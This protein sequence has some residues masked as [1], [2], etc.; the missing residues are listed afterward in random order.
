MAPPRTYSESNPTVV[1]FAKANVSYVDSN[2]KKQTRTDYRPAPGSGYEILTDDVLISG[3]LELLNKFQKDH[4]AELRQEKNANAKRYIDARIRSA[5]KFRAL[6]NKAMLDAAQKKFPPKQEVVDKDG[7][8][9]LADMKYPDYQTS[10]NGCWS[11]SYSLLLKSRG[12]ELSQEEIRQWRPDYKENAAPDTKPNSERKRLMNVDTGNSIYPNAD[13]VGK[14]LPNTAVN[15]LHLDPFEPG[16]LSID[17]KPLSAAQQQTVQEEYHAQVKEKLQTTI[18]ESFAQHQSPVS[19]S[20]DGHFITITGISADG[21]TIRYEESLGAENNSPR[22]RTMTMDELVK[23]G[24]SAH[25]HNGVQYDR[26]YG[27]E[28]TWL[29]DLPVAEHGKEQPGLHPENKDYVTVGDNGSVTVSVPGNDEAFSIAGSPVQGQV[30]SRAVEKQMVLDQ[31][32]LARRLG[33]KKIDG[34]G[35]GGGILCGGAGTFYPG[36][37]MRPGDPSLAQKA[38]ASQKKNISKVESGLNYMQ[39]QVYTEESAQK[40]QECLAALKDLKAIAKGDA[41]DL[42]KDKEKLSGLCDYLAQKPEGSDKTHF[43]EIFYYM[44]D[45]SRKAF[46]ENLSHFNVLLGLGKEKECGMFE[47]LHPKMEQ[48][49]SRQVQKSTN[50]IKLNRDFR[51]KIAGYWDTVKKNAAGSEPDSPEQKQMHDAL[52]K[53]AATYTLY[54]QMRDAG[55]DPPYPSEEEISAL[56]PKIQSFDAFQNTVNGSKDWM[57]TSVPEDFVKAFAAEENRLREATKD[58]NRYAIPEAYLS[59]RQNRFKSIAKRLDK[60]ETGSYTGL[61]VIS[62]RKNSTE[63]EKAKEA[64]RRAGNADAPSALVVK[65]SVDTVLTYLAGKEKKRNREFGRQRWTECMR[66]LADAMPRKEFEAYCK[67]V[68][69]VRG[70]GPGSKD[71]I[72]PENF[73]P[74]NVKVTTVIKDSINRIQD[75]NNTLRDYARVIAARDFGDDGG[76]LMKD[77]HVNSESARDMLRQKTDEILSDP[78]FKE[79][80][81]NSPKEELLE[82]MK[83][84]DSDGFWIAWKDYK[85]MNSLTAESSEKTDE[86]LSRQTTI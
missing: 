64:I 44:N 82:M 65:R 20:W 36:R 51:N 10:A 29:S 73:Y 54:Q 60:T 4:Q 58:V 62:R 78:H 76:L 67:H 86:T 33:V 70:V 45:R 85:E 75:G 12:V 84:E 24:M 28:L 2:G 74:P 14:V 52:A 77:E 37:V 21:N 49:Y 68:N 83:S 59:R 3:D 27:I 43:E 5:E 66:F 8:I 30:D 19:A 17:G 38:L 16:M 56:A 23:Q 42:E 11:A 35:P 55:K 63:F 79:F 80:I 26:G 47:K 53:I 61:G 71:Y 72:G 46:V 25:I 41:G 1:P 50:H 7:F 34:I 69:E 39:N 48:E 32:K 40:A 15:N 9:G 31:T 22:T 6:E 57:H 13:L 81:E 18:L